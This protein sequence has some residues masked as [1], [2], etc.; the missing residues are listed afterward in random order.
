MEALISAFWTALELCALYLFWKAFLKPKVSRKKYILSVAG[1]FALTQIYMNIR[2][3]QPWTLC[4]SMSLNIGCSFL[5][6]RG[7]WYRHIAAVLFCMCTLGTM[8]VFF[9]YGTSSVL[10]ISL[11]TLVWRKRTYVVVATAGK[12][13]AILAAWLV[14]RF[15]KFRDSQPLQGKWLFLSLLFPFTSVFTLLF[16]FQNYKENPDISFEAVFFCVILVVANIAILYFID[17]M[18]KSAEQRKENALLNQQMEIQTENIVAL[19]KSYRTQRQ[20]TH[21]FRNQLQAIS[22]LLALGRPED[23]MDYVQQLLGQTTTRIFC[24]N[25]HHPIID[26]VLNYKYQS[27]KDAGIDI[28]VEVNDLS[29]VSIPTDKLIVLLSN[30]L[31]NSIEGC[32]RLEEDRI[33]QCRFVAEDTLALSIRNTSPP[34][35]ILDGTIPT[36]KEPRAEHGYGLSRIQHILNQLHAEFAFDYQEGW[37][38][39]VAEIPLCPQ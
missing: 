8:D 39:F 21:D 30:L 28:Q 11:E 1:L 23:A 27:A 35:R 6:N 33:I 15:S 9:A 19:E 26:A 10:G 34:V 38:T 3:G 17:F 22:S 31:D 13:A 36:S 5:V 14:Y 18:Q 29:Q 20:I 2:L 37:F 4:L 12:V 24:V 16:I 7:K 25:S 32:C